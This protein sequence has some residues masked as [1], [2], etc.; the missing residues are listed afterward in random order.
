LK[1]KSICNLDTSALR[2]L[3]VLR[4]CGS[5]ARV[6]EQ[7]HL[8]SS[9]VFCQIRQLE[10][11]L[12]QK[13]YE[14]RGKVLELTSAGNS[15]A[16]YAVQIIQMH[17]STVGG[18]RLSGTGTREVI[19][20]G[21]GPHGSVAILPFLILEFVKQHPKIELEMR[22]ADDN[23]M[24]TDL[25]VGMLDVLL[26]SVPDD[27]TRL[28]QKHLWSYELGLVF[29]PT[30]M[31]LFKNPSFN[32]LH[33]APFILYHRPVLI[34]TAFQNLCRDLGYEPNV[35]MQNDD[36]D[37]I[38]ELVMLGLGVSLLPIWVVAEE[39]R[40]GKLR[41]VRLP[42]RRFYRYGV[43]CRSSAYAGNAVGHFIKVAQ[44]WKRWWPL[45]QHVEPAIQTND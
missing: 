24:L 21:C 5:F 34:D 43:L 40:R 38:K 39:A 36:P 26:I 9:A 4:Q 12:G 29:P 19:R 17:D 32:D 1:R 22:S 8:S 27:V 31:G 25:R 44:Q 28:E 15:L 41:I 7:V 2:A 10:D 13:L 16:E 14:R 35:V 42:K 3:L 37:S 20:V 18:L 23:T 11:Q 30:K 6:S 45:A 33:K